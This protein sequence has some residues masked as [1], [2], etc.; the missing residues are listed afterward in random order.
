MPE[1][2]ILVKLLLVTNILLFMWSQGWHFC[3]YDVC[4]CT[5]IKETCR[6]VINKK[7]VPISLALINVRKTDESSSTAPPGKYMDQNLKF[8][9][10]LF[11]FWSTLLLFISNVFQH[12]PEMCLSCP[13]IETCQVC[14]GSARLYIETETSV[15]FRNITKHK[16]FKSLSSIYEK[17]LWNLF[18]ININ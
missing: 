8:F 4:G 6:F 10:W 14:R 1:I 7:G 12:S 5:T 18:V 11:M 15:L 17:Y 3:K 9:I 2:Y 16:K 13:T